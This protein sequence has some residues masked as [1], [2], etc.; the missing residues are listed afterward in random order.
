MNLIIQLI[1]HASNI[2][3]MIFLIRILLQLANADFNNPIAQFIH[4]FTFPVLNPLRS[5]IPD[6]GKFNTASLVIAVSILVLKLFLLTTILNQPL[7]S[8]AYLVGTLIGFSSAQGLVMNF[9]TLL[10]VL[11]IG[12]MVVSFISGG[13][14]HPAM[15]FFNQVTS[16]ILNPLRKIIP[17]IGGALDI[18]PAIVLFILIYGQGILINLGR[19]ILS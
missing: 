15:S 10:T 7:S 13:K 17:P 19:S 4:K 16:P 18:T 12:L 3:C 9:I 5:I 11:F 1:E 2:I 8:K 6:L 14:Y